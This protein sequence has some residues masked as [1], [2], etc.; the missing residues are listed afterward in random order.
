[1]F[2]VIGNKFCIHCFR[3]TIS[4]IHVSISENIVARD[5]LK[6][7]KK[8]PEFRKFSFMG[9]IGWFSSKC[10]KKGVDL[11]RIFDKEKDEYHEIVKDINTGKILHE[12]HE[13]LSEHT[14]HGSAKI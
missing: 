5:S 8:S 4:N 9:V 12:T 1:M 14:G 2:K 13:K 3:N 10:Y 7:K 6:F 11:S